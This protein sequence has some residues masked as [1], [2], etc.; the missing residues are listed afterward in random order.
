[1]MKLAITK[2]YLLIQNIQLTPIIIE[3]TLPKI[4]P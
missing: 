2:H 4:P 1:M 3:D